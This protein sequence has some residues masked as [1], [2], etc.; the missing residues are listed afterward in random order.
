M[1]F[2]NT[3]GIGKTGA[4]LAIC[5]LLLAAFSGSLWV[6]AQGKAKLTASSCAVQR[7]DTVS[8]AFSLEENPGI[9]GL[10]FK[11]DYDHSV[12][13]LMAAVNGAVFSDS[14]ITQPESLDRE[15]FLF[16]GCSDELE[17]ITGNGNVVTLMFKVSDNAP[18]KEYPVTLEILQ[19][20]DLSGQDVGISAQK[21]IVTVEEEDGDEPDVAEPPRVTE[22]PKTTQAPQ[23]TE[24]PRATQAPRVTEAPGASQGSSV[25]QAPGVTQ[26]PRMTE[27]PRPT[28]AP[29][30]TQAPRSTEAPEASAGIG[31]DKDGD[32]DKD[33]QG[34]GSVE[35][36]S[37]I[38]PE[39]DTG[40][41]KDGGNL[42]LWIALGLLGTVVLLLLGV[43]CR[44]AQLMHRRAM[45]RE[46]A[47][48]RRK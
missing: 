1:K 38:N 27:A 22:V 28:Q 9:W 6:C 12:L 20:I 21:G 33:N 24:A 45:D 4:I 31:N 42:A 41:K 48:R 18:F 10:K 30:T 15:S 36:V 8:V 47:K 34:Q 32:N 5:F 37:Q 40:G 23:V 7:G 26:A 44:K 19:A 13:K 11:A 14:E 46:A 25:T 39:R 17:N 2:G 35:T 43:C 3:N 29:G 16:L